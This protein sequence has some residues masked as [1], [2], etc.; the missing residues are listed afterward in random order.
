MAMAV[1]M[2]GGKEQLIAG[3]P[4]DGEHQLVL[5]FPV[6]GAGTVLRG[7]FFRPRVGEYG[8]R[9]KHGVPAAGIADHSVAGAVIDLNG[10]GTVHF[11]K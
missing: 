2:G 6:Q 3:P 4:Q 5:K 10:L 1:R 9:V 11:F 7:Q 8:Q